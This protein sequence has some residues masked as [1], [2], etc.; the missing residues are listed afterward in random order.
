MYKLI[1]VLISCLLKRQIH[2]GFLKQICLSGVRRDSF[3][4]IRY[5]REGYS[6]RGKLESRLVRWII[7][8]VF[9]S[10]GIGRTQQRKMVAETTFKMVDGGRN[11]SKGKWPAGWCVR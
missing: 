11:T 4:P 6:V 9:D 10:G 2:G 5:L 8:L 7:E 3:P 1:H